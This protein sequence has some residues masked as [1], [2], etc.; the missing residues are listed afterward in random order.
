M[1][2]TWF[3]RRLAVSLGLAWVV[4]T[5]V[6][7][8]LHMVPGDPAELL[9]STGGISPD[10]AAVAELREKLGLERP[11]LAQYG[12][13]LAG[14]MQ[15]NLGHSL[16]DDYPVL[17]EIALRLPRTLELI[18]AGTLIGIAVGVPSGVYAAL[19]RGGRFDRIAS[20]VT[21]LL[22]AVPVF[23][24]GTLLV[25]LMAQT[26]RL[27]PAGG[28]VPFTQDPAQHLK[29][30]TLPA[31]AV[32]K[33]LAAILF[34][35]TRASMLDALANDYVRTARAKGLSQ[36]RILVVHVLRN[37][38]NP[39]LTV[40]GLQMGTLLGGTV[41][42]EYVFNWPGLSTPLLRAVEARDYPMVVGII[43]TIS[44]LFLLINLVV[45]ILHAIV[46][47]RVQAG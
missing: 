31:L 27:M 47:P 30:L 39:V 24:V 2:A 29:L 18:L 32:G 34:R 13:F 26:L 7:L 14:L 19:H 37:A 33:G 40:L 5:I 36:A 20:G 16:V 44:V 12:A 9:L 10:P 22:L 38:L 28:F 8:A 45:E 23:V 43:L 11:L 46:D 35:M 4:A 42:V 3:A 25:L 41:L 21:A 17:S 1:S 6:F 15:G